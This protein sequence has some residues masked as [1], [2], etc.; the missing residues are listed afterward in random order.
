MRNK[1]RVLISIH[2]RDE[3]SL[4]DNRPRLGFSAFHWGFLIQPKHSSGD[5]T[6][7]YDIS[8]ASVPDPITRLDT[9]PNHDWKFRVKKRVDIMGSGRLLGRI[10]IGKVPNNV[11]STEI[12][13]VLASVPFPIK[14]TEENCVSWTMDAIRALQEVKLAEAF[15]VDQFMVKGLELADKWLG[16]ANPKNFHN[17]TQ[18]PA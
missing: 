11:T 4:G 13:N 1:R 6:D 7:A 14:G 3:S 18:R 2:H 16:Q 9:N 12:E 15:D 5:D 8:D 17:H 10:M